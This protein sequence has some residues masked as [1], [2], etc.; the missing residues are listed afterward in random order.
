MLGIVI[1]VHLIMIVYAIRLVDKAGFAREWLTDYRSL[2][3]LLAFPWLVIIAERIFR[4]YP[5][6]WI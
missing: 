3:L 6:G 2:V 5:G 1:L 4:R